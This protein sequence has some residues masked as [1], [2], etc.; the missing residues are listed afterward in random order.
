MR[1]PSFFILAYVVLAVQIGLSGHV[2]WGGA[3]PNLVLPVAVFVAINARREEALLAVF[4]LGGLQD[5]F[6]Q[7]PLGLYAFC[8]SLVGLFVVGTQP[9]VR[10]DHPLTH[11]FLSMAAALF[12]GCV[13]LF[14]DWAYPR[15]HGLAR[16]AHPSILQSLMRAV[17]TA[18]AAPV[19]LAGLVRIKRV[20]GFR[21]FRNVAHGELQSLAIRQ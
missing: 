13:S 19:L 18:L 2:T 9:A 20:F 21:G 1:W 14:N 10:R 8:Y 15:L 16:Y 17:Y 3:S 7:Q 6:T 5:L 4:L 12:T 11:L